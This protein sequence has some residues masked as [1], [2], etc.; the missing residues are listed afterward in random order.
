LFIGSAIV[1]RGLRFAVLAWLL[2]RYGEPIRDFIDKRLGL[3]AFGVAAI[4]IMLY[5][6][7]RLLVGHYS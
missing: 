2:R 6:A 7:F 5:V 3:I 1:A 4:I